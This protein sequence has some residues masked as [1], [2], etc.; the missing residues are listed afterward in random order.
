MNDRWNSLTTDRIPPHDV[1]AT[2]GPVQINGEM[3]PQSG[4]TVVSPTYSPPP[5]INN[6][7]RLCLT[8]KH[9]LGI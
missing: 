3:C 2:D 4:E 8:V 5:H 7:I 9:R 1:V 6:L